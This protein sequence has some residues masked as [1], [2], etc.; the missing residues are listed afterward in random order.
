MFDEIETV[1]EEEGFHILGR[2]ISED[3]SLVEASI[4]L[5]VPPEDFRELLKEQDLE[6]REAS[7]EDLIETAAECFSALDLNSEDAY[8]YFEKEYEIDNQ[9][10]VEE[11]LSA[12]LERLNVNTDQFRISKR[13][14]RQQ[15]KQRIWEAKID[16]G[17]TSEIFWDELGD[18]N[19]YLGTHDRHN[20]K[21]VFPLNVIYRHVDRPNEYTA[22][23]KTVQAVTTDEWE[24]YCNQAY[25]V[26][27]K[28]AE[29]S[30]VVNDWNDLERRFSDSPN[31][32]HRGGQTYWCVELEA[33]DGWYALN[34]CMTMLEFLLGRINF[35]LTRNQIEGGQIN[36]SVWNTR[37]RN[38]RSP[39]IYLIF[40]DGEYA[41]FYSSSDP[42]PRKPAKLSSHKAERYQ[43]N[44]DTIP[45]MNGE[46]DDM[47]NR[48]VKAVRSFQEAVTDTDRENTFLNYWRAA[49]RLTLMSETESTSTVVNRARTVARTSNVVSQSEVCHKRNKLVHEGDSVEITTDDTNTVK[50]MLE[51]LILLYVEKASEWQ[52]DD[53]LFF[54]E[55]G[56]KS[57]DALG[58]LERKRHTELELIDEIR[59]QA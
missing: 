44:L 30:M 23:N 35:A 11:S 7:K 26:E 9:K 36:S 49:E 21:I 57:E 2:Y 43:K 18:I 55:H 29:E 5:S 40:K 52:H 6:V 1:T 22:L 56:D 15:L 8:I 25:G 33:I 19:R 42:T 24:Q 14:L 12:I 45:P 47:E 34:A 37:W 46:L 48:L 54:F 58:Q 50:G 16:D 53:L 41:D 51:Y 3:I 4:A 59:E 38:L 32:L 27:Q 17:D 31:P 28:K 10:Q 39:F 13:E 20:Y